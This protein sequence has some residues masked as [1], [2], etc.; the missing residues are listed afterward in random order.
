MKKPPPPMT[1]SRLITLLI[2]IFTC[3]VFV[4]TVASSSPLLAQGVK[5]SGSAPADTGFPA[6][7]KYFEIVKRGCDAI[8]EN[9]IDTY[10]EQHSGMILSVLNHQ[11]A[12][13][14]V[15]VLP[16]APH[17]VRRPDRTGLGGS[18]A[19]L[20]QNLY[21]VMRSLSRLTGDDRYEKAV[22]NAIADF[23]RITQHP[24]TGLL[25]WGEHLYWN[26]VEDRLGDMDYPHQTHEPK[27]PFIYFDLAYA[28][29]PQRTLNYARGLWEHQ[30]ACKE[31]GDFSRHAKYN[32][33]GPSRGH[34]FPK[35]GSFFIK[36]WSEA[37]AKTQ[38]PYYAN[39]VKVLARRYQDRMNDRHLLEWESKGAPDRV[40]KCVTLWMVSL[41]LESHDAASR[42][43]PETAALL[44]E[45]AERL[46][47]GFLALPHMAAVPEQ[48]FV[49]FAFTDSGK[50]R[51]DPKKKSDGYSA[52]VGMGYGIST[53]SMFATLCYSRSK[54]IGDTP[55][56][57]AYR[58]LVVQAADIYSNMRFDPKANDVW[59]GEYGFAIFTQLAAF[60]LTKNQAYLLAAQKIADHAIADLWDEGNAVLPRASTRTDYY[61]VISYGDTTMLAFLALYEH[62]S[63]M[64]PIVPIS[65]I[66]R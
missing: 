57:V 49:A 28:L 36:T 31:T 38:D 61:D 13:P 8:L 5:G 4:T 55:A 11:T 10:G 39:A 62:L 17:G 50:P 51:P 26:C 43:D 33:H 65:D 44:T 30:I 58:K 9:A 47:K 53:T 2:R 1:H 14:L 66:V 52:T 21:R 18:N 63:G 46:D 42:M 32:V 41:A 54:Q 12:K 64:D 37:Y 25:A 22:R 24:D 19:N 48:A 20:Q 35:E 34:D 59:A 60:R 23:F 40:N 6:P 29:E 16:R 56:G 3:G 7:T 27:L 45:L 15:D